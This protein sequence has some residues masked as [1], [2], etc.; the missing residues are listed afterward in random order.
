MTKKRRLGLMPRWQRLLTWWGLAVCTLSGC[1]YLL[2]H[3]FGVLAQS[4]GNHSVL[5]VHGVSAAGVIFIVGTVATVHIQ[6][7][8]V[9]KKSLFSGFFQLFVL[10]LLITTGLLLYYGTEEIRDLAVFIHWTFGLSVMPVFVF[11]AS[12]RWRLPSDMHH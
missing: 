12:K 2:G 3:E 11:H 8:L 7:G 1:A 9:A 6:A 4:I 5:V 10:V